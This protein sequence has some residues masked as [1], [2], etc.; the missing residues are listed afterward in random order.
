MSLITQFPNCAPTI[1]DEFNTGWSTCSGD[2][3]SCVSCQPDEK[4]S[5]G[6][7]MVAAGLDCAPPSCASE[8]CKFEEEP[9]PPGPSPPGPSPPGPSPPVP[10]PEPPVATEGFFQTTTGKVAAGVG[11]LILVVALIF[12]LMSLKKKKNR[13]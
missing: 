13:R 8:C 7:M 9:S 4:S 10:F 5:C 3:T 6:S 2:C 11:I 12:L 1:G